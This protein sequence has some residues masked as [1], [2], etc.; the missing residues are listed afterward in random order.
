MKTRLYILGLLILAAIGGLLAVHARWL[1]AG[2]KDPRFVRFLRRYDKRANAD[3]ILPPHG[4]AVDERGQ[5]LDVALQGSTFQHV[6]DDLSLTTRGQTPNA[7]ITRGQAPAA[8]GQVAVP[9]TLD[10]DLQSRAEELMAGKNGAVVALEPATGRIRALVSAPRAAYLDRALN[11]L[12]PPGSVFKVFVAA[13]ALS[14]DVDPVLNCPAEGYRSS[15]S[16]P[17]IRDVEARQAARSGRRWK[18]FGKIGMA[19]ALAH[20][21][22][23][24]FAQLGVMLGPERFGTVVA[25]A[26]LREPVTVLSAS[27]LSLD[28]AGGSVPDGLKAAQLAPVAIGQGELQLSPLAVAMLTAAVADDGV[29]LSPTLSPTA[30][31]ALRAR[32]FTYAAAGRVK[33]MMRAAVRAGTGTACDLPGLAVCGKTGTA[34]TGRGKDHAWFTCF[35]PMEAPRLVVTVLVEHGGFGARAA[36]PIA[37]ELLKKARE[38][39]YFA[40]GS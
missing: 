10:A 12:Y 22:N 36:L 24:Y 18:G 11:G 21:S 40:E 23:T 27:S 8:D 5:T 3:D 17:P 28:A 31:P 9:L 37:R 34:E 26:K 33:K 25:A 35:A 1:S 7:P 6:L 4:V 20:S 16:T 30:K 2:P 38:L 32:P 14:A 29:M 15:R 19:E 13:A 39:G